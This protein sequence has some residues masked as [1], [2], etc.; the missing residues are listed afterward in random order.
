MNNLFY[1]IIERF[2]LNYIRVMPM[3]LTNR[4]EIALRAAGEPRREPDYM[5]ALLRLR[6]TLTPEQDALLLQL[7]DDFAG[8]VRYE[9]RWYFRKG[10][11]AAK[12]ETL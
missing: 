2:V 11:R 6:K 1:C 4:E 5:D 9:R 12:K 8:L 10:Y 3:K 7:L